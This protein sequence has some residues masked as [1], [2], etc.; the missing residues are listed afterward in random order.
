MTVVALGVSKAAGGKVAWW[1]FRTSKCGILRAGIAILASVLSED[2]GCTVAR[3]PVRISN[4]CI[5]GAKAPVLVFGFSYNWDDSF[6]FWALLQ[7][8]REDVTVAGSKFKVGSS[9][10][11]HAIALLVGRRLGSAVAGSVFKVW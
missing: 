5:P 7:G 9:L 4:C 8:R 11:E 3:W 1:P 6:G 2:S 10:S